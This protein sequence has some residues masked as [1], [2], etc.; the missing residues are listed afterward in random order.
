MHVGDVLA[1]KYRVDKV[2]GIGGMGMVV[3]ATH[4]Q[5]GQRVALKFMLP[6][7]LAS[8]QAVERF[9]REARSVVRLRSEHVCQVFDVGTLDTGAPYIVMEL[10]DGQ[11]LHQLIARRKCLP[12]DEAVELVLQALEGIAVAHANAIVHRDLKPANL[13]I[14]T[15][16]DG[17]PLVKVLD[18]GISKSPIDG[19]A[20]RTGDIMGSP[21]FMAPEQMVSSKDVDVRADV[22]AIGVILY[23]AISGRLP[24]QGKTFPALCVAVMS[25]N[26]PRLETVA[27]VPEA[28]AAAVMRCL[29]TNREYRFAS[30]A[31]LAAALAPFGDA[32][33]RTR[34]TR[35]AKVLQRAT[36]AIPHPG[37][38]PTMMSDADL[39]A[40]TQASIG[41]PHESTFG[42]SA[43][44][45]LRVVPR[46][47][48]SRIVIAAVTIATVA[49]AIIVVAATGSSGTQATQ[50]V[51]APSAPASAPTE[52]EP[53]P[54][55][56]V[57]RPAVAPTATAIAPEPPPTSIV[58]TPAVTKPAVTKPISKPAS[59]TVSPTVS[60]SPSPAAPPVE[61]AKPPA[62][63][64]LEPP[65]DKPASKW[66]HLQHDLGE[67]R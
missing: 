35:I 9:T 48:W 53:T 59:L 43:G 67:G 2:L 60:P 23:Q 42:A 14:A 50:P 41:H 17:T 39:L 40:P 57:S 12:V 5:L 22:W 61:T 64:E 55:A 62:S 26:P 1:G 32:F 63:P 44:E 33:A 4:L 31:E 6:E 54:T 16:G 47:R 10:M 65:N 20:T 27:A 29:A 19:A 56:E 25:G 30:V 45:A 49:G 15:D 11:D 24:F 66:G 3:A 8:P 34:A 51:N 28:L 13:F 58:Q 46:R 52:V 18:F 37:L 21:A 7:A 36:P 38:A